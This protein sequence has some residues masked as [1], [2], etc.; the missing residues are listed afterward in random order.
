MRA[1][2]CHLLAL[3]S[4]IPLAEGAITVAS[5]ST[6]WSPFTGRY[7][8]FDDQGTGQPASDIVGLGDD[9]GFFFAFD[10]NGTP[11]ISTDGNLAFRIRFDVAGDKKD[12]ANFKGTVWVGIDADLNGVIDV[13][14]GVDD[15]GSSTDIVI[16][17]AGGGAN[18]SPSTTTISSSHYY[19]E[20]ADENN[21]SYRPVD[22]DNSL[23][24]GA[25]GGTTNDITGNG[26][27]DYYLSFV[28]PFQ[29]VVSF[30]APANGG[31]IDIT[32]QSP[33]RYVVV[34]SEQGNALNQDIGGV[35]GNVSGSGDTPWTEISGPVLIPEP[36]SGILALG[37]MLGC[38]LIRRRR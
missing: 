12:P 13:F 4:M 33:M 14:L 1:L 3:F 23:G 20:P 6:E 28:V 21:Y 19:T 10:D 37:S 34:T 31:P 36:S 22:W 38:L 35:D 26:D 17:A 15:K 5:P 29:Q 27:N 24:N 16:T 2:P 32:D 11:S 8:Y 30:L 9:F 25:D 7:D 18:T